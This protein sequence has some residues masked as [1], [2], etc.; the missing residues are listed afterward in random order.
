MPRVRKGAARHRSKNRVRKAVKG[1]QSSRGRM[2]R[3]AK[4]AAKRALA[5]NYA[6]RRK[7][8]R[9]FRRLWITR[10]NAACRAR[11]MS[12]SRFIAALTKKSIGINR[13]M[14]AIMAID[15]PVDFD[16]LVEM[17]KAD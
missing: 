17:A 5:F 7:R 10:I 1:Y 15:D 9:D 12:Y 8:A 11:G 6:H 16:K 2:Y 13:Q 3:V 4:E 14:L